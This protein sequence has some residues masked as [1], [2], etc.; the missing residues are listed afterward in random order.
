M[1]IKS[2]FNSLRRF[3]TRSASSQHPAVPPD[4]AADQRFMRLYRRCSD[5]TMTSPERMYAQYRAVVRVV[6]Y[7][8]VGD[9]VEC[10]VWRG[11]SSMLAALTLLEYG[12]RNRNL[13]LYDTFSGM[14]APTNPDGKHAQSKWQT[15][16]EQGKLESWCYATHDE[17]SANM[18]TT[19]Y[20]SDRIILVKGKVENTIPATA[21]EHIALLRLDTDWYES[22]H[23]EMRHLFPRLTTGGIFIEDDYG[24]WEGSR[25]AVDEYLAAHAPHLFLSRIDETG[26]QAIKHL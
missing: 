26:V 9:I 25:R 10:G 3:F 12:D 1:N 21:P 5:F 20:P 11:G 4:I 13:Y 19:G 18:L 17:V 22:T 14:P 24:K 15:K 16:A 2:Y 7:G 23:H 6:T 8:I